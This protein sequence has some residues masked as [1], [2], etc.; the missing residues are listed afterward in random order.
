MNEKT[1]QELL[2][3]V[4]EDKKDNLRTTS[5]K[6]KTDLWNFFSEEGKFPFRD[7]NAVEFGTHKGQTTRIM[8]HLFKNVYTVNLPNHFDEAMFL[9]QDMENIHYIPMDLYQTEVDD[10]F[11][12]EPITMFFIDALHTFEGIMSD[13]TRCLNMKLAKGDNFII[14]DDYGQS[15]RE[16]FMAVNQLIK[17]GQ[18]ERVIYIGHPPYYSF[19]GNPER[20]LEDHEGIICKIIK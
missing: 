11:K 7:K 14:F 6:F 2:A 18:L 3:E 16:V 8:A 19:G 17:V 20:K 15:S 12:H 4:K 10:N 13:V 1:I 5:F 9:N